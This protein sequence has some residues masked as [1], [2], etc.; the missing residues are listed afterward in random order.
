[1]PPKKIIKSISSKGTRAVTKETKKTTVNG[2]TIVE[3]KTVRV[4]K[5]GNVREKVEKKEMKTTA[6]KATSKK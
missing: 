1:M 3:E 4:F 2:K 5:N 6:R